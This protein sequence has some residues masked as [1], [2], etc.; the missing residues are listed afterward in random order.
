MLLDE[1]D[2]NDTERL[3]TLSD[4]TSACKTAVDILN[5]LLCFDMMESG[6]LEL[7]KQD[8]TVFTFLYDNIKLFAT[9]AKGN[10]VELTVSA[11][12]FEAEQMTSSSC[13]GVGVGINPNHF[14]YNSWILKYVITFRFTS[15]FHSINI[16]FRFYF[17]HNICFISLFIFYY[18]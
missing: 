12:A 7:H 9:Q 10:G 11:E 5:D 13:S 17:I 3:D 4:V 18:F 2:P 1:T 6:I 8:I 14:N 16:T 15:L